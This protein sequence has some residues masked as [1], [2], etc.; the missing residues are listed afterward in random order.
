MLDPLLKQL[1]VSLG[2]PF[3]GSPEALL[4]Y[5]LK[6]FSHIPYENITKINSYSEFGL[7]L[8]KHSPE[9]L[10]AKFISSGTGGTCFPLSLTLVRFIR[11]IGFEAYPILADRRYG[12]DTHSAVIFRGDK[13]AWR[14]IDPGYLINTP[15]LLPEP[16]S[17]LRYD[18]D[19]NSI[20]L[21]GNDNSVQVD[22]YTLSQSNSLASSTPPRYRLTYKITPV[23][24]GEFNIAWDRSFTFEMMS[25]PVISVAHGDKH[26]Y[27][28]KDTLTVRDRESKSRLVLP[29]EQFI[30]ES[31]RLT[32]ISQE[33]LATTIKKLS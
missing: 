5:T 33:I 8:A 4:N 27:I 14:L 16:Y 12:I 23:D 31:S 7:R 29:V 19:F 1:L 21:R 10:I 25:Y 20:E 22:L 6:A 2:Y 11:A 24:E 9:E 32:G 28:Q 13:S 17:S 18:L 30:I 26:I 15:C 3:S